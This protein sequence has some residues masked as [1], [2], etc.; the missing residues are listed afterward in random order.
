MKKCE[1]RNISNGNV[2]GKVKNGHNRL[3][4]GGIKRLANS[5]MVYL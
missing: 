2:W 1:N 5:I 3:Q 4:Q